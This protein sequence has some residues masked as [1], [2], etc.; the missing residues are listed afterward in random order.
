MSARWYYETG[1]ERDYWLGSEAG[2]AGSYEFQGTVFGIDGSNHEGCMG[3]GCC[4]W[5]APEADQ[6]VR[7]G[8]EEE[9]TS[10][11]CAGW[12]VRPAASCQQDTVP[13]LITMRCAS[14]TRLRCTCA[15]ELSRSRGRMSRPRRA[16]RGDSSSS[17]AQLA[18]GH[19]TLTAGAD[20]TPC[21]GRRR[22]GSPPIAEAGRGSPSPPA[23]VARGLRA[24]PG[25]EC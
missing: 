11:S 19:R 8:R 23:V 6:R 10:P 14:S 5:G 9:G 17:P 16:A 2:R 15:V 22:Q 7:V 20:G 24:G 4:R 25:R 1:L 3:S 21:S 12:H 13:N 18:S